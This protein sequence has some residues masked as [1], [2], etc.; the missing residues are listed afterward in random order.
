MATITIPYVFTPN[1]TILSTQVNANFST[2]Q[3]L[4]NGQ[5]DNSNISTTANIA[6]SK[7]GLNPGQAAFNKTTTGNQTWASGLTTDTQPQVAM[8]S[9]KGLQ[10]GPGGAVGLDVKLQRSALNTLQLSTPGGGAALLDM[11]LGTIF[12]LRTMTFD[13]AAAV[14]NMNGGSIIGVGSLS[15]PNPANAGVN[16]LRAS[17]SSTL[18]IAPNGS[19]ITS[20]S[21][22]PYL[23]SFMGLYNGTGW[24]L[25][26]LGA[27]LTVAVPPTTNT[28]YD[29]AV[30]YNSGTPQAVVFQWVA[31]NTPPAGR[32]VQNGVPYTNGNARYRLIA[33]FQTGAVAGQINDNPGERG[34]INIYNT[35]PRSLAAQ[36]PVASWTYNVNTLRASNANVTNGQGRVAFILPFANMSVDA[37]FTQPYSQSSGAAASVN[38]AQNA[39]GLDSTTAATSAIC[40]TSS[41]VSGATEQP[42]GVNVATVSLSNLTA[43]QHYLQMLEAADATPRTWTF[44]GNGTPGHSLTGT[45]MA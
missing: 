42:G 32:G 24:T 14:L 21:I 3:T 1:T 10:F 31:A 38:H 4:V 37:V 11:N 43:G 28:S 22:L 30:D 17:S 34:L 2:I 33:V 16:G 27:G 40:S 8:F 15:G 29:L 9:D 45:I 20:I 18:A 35:V 36:I 19:A 26:D 41:S 23:S 39:I 6:L 12:N 7:L 44:Y 13:S 25:S 5:I